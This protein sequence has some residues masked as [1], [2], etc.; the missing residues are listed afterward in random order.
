MVVCHS[1]VLVVD[2]K[3]IWLVAGLKDPSAGS[4]GHIVCVLDVTEDARET[5]RRC[6]ERDRII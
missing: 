2:P 6:T 3:E 4:I 1:N 5:W